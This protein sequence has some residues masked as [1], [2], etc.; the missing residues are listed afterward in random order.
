MRPVIVFF[1]ALTV[2]SC[3]VKPKQTTPE[4]QE[5]SSSASFLAPPALP[6]DGSPSWKAEPI[7]VEMHPLV[8]L[9]IRYFQTKGRDLM[10]R[11][12]SRSTRYG[13]LMRDILRYHGLPEDLIYIALIE[14]G[15]S[16]RAI[17]HA[18]AVGYWQ[19]IK[20]TGRRY[21]LEINPLIDERRDP[22]L[23]THA[24]AIYF[25]ELYSM[26]G[27]WYLAMAGYNAGEHKISR[28]IQKYKTR[29][30][31]DLIRYRRALPRETIHYVPKFI[32]AKLIA[33]NP[34]EY[35]FTDIEY[36]E[37]L[38]FE[39]VTLV[40]PVDLR[41]MAQE[42][43]IEYEELKI[44]NPR[45]KGPLAP[46]YR[47]GQLELRVPVAKKE[48]ALQAAQKAMVDPSLI[49]FYKSDDI[50][51][52]RVRRGESLYSIAK[53]YR[54]TIQVLR[55]L[56]DLRPNRRLRVG[57]RIDVPRPT[58]RK[59]SSDRRSQVLPSPL[60]GSPLSAS[61]DAPLNVPPDPEA[62]QTA[63]PEK[64]KIHI[65]Q[66]G[67][68]LYGIAEEYDVSI[69]ELLRLNGLKRRSKLQIGMRLLLPDVEPMPTAV[70]EKEGL[71]SDSRSYSPVNHRKNSSG[72][73]ELKDVTKNSR[74]S[75]HVKSPYRRIQH[76]IHVVRRGDSLEKIAR[77]YQIS[78]SELIQKNNLRQ[79][80]VIRVGRKLII[81][82]AMN[83]SESL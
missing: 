18:S 64:V 19:F 67:D 47:D 70:T 82:V 6:Q 1:V 12:L 28:L 56:N 13:K 25:K 22:V 66:K 16:S 73:I 63:A 3:A 75:S 2:I 71:R 43:E 30:F 14:S 8:D 31:W 58:S 54:T 26:F 23:S 68:T 21:Q 44:L 37:P 59:P 52:H 7:A 60:E 9:W 83:E 39:T 69:Q 29:N 48:L 49:A 10:V 74:K 53:R 62:S 33:E 72:N 32:A 41:K 15:F 45:Y 78:I 51:T 50:L 27:S 77:K 17:S 20:S 79:N 40:F 38:T 55:D 81:P 76:R 34:E 57:Q 36:E 61:V 42:L 5:P 24:A 46:P 35:G 80:D 11:Y 65:V 4:A